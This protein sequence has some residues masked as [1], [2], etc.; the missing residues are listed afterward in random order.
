MVF[1][2]RVSLGSGVN[3]AMELADELVALF[4]RKRIPPATRIVFSSPYVQDV[5]EEVVKGS[6]DDKFY[7]V[8]VI[9]PYIRRENFTTPSPF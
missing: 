9:C 7:R 3:R 1:S 8:D 2:V 4:L 6:P 5:G